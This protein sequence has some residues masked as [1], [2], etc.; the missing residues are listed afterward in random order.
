[1]GGDGNIKEKPTDSGE[2][3]EQ[4]VKGNV[5]RRGSH[6]GNKDA[7]G[8]VLRKNVQVWKRDD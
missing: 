6:V 8:G 3:G 2:G 1:V 5:L 7:A 4:N